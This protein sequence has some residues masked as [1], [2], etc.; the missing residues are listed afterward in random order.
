[1]WSEDG[2]DGKEPTYTCLFC[3]QAEEQ[4]CLAKGTKM[5]LIILFPDSG[6]GD[7]TSEQSK[8]WRFL[9]EKYSLS[10]DH[11]KIPVISFGMKP[12]RIQKVSKAISV[13]TCA[14]HEG[15][16]LNSSPTF[17]ADISLWYRA[18]GCPAQHTMFSCIY[19]LFPYE[20]K[21]PLCPHYVVSPEKPTSGTK[22]SLGSP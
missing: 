9:T 17:K 11:Q 13:S 10:E 7:L 19:S 6:F 15:R 3:F 2:E 1:M 22:E 21:S 8:K 20:A 14:W 12:Q 4:F 5:L 16:V 18:G